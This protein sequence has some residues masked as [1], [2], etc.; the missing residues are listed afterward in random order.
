MS[1]NNERIEWL[2][3]GKGL[4][5][6][7]VV[8][9]H[10]ISEYLGVDHFGFFLVNSFSMPTFFAMSGYVVQ[11]K[12]ISFGKYAKQ[13]AKRLL[14]PYALFAM[15]IIFARIAMGVLSKANY[16]ATLTKTD[17]INTIT[18]NSKSIVSSLWFLPVLF[19]ADLV[20]YFIVR[21]LK[22]RKE[23]VI[24]CITAA[25]IILFIKNL[26]LKGTTIP[27]SIDTVIV[28]LSF[29]EL[30]YEIRQGALDVSK[31]ALPCWTFYIS[32]TIIQYFILHSKEFAFYRAESSYPL[33]SF[34]CAVSSA[35]GLIWLFQ[36]INW[37]PLIN[38]FGRHSLYIYGFHFLVQNIVQIVL[39]K[40]ILHS[41]AIMIE[42]IGIALLAAV[43]TVILTEIATTIYLWT[44]TQILS[45][46][47]KNSPVE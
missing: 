19:L 21:Y 8:I 16:L 40:R 4:M 24:V 35:I 7:S 12:D 31:W 30:G 18:F 15:L 10:S 47:L 38:R 2:D 6:F 45:R 25:V 5:I 43:I 13:K 23:R 9:A 22:N 37:L 42:T 33:L 14:P 1:K 41:K 36:K 39:C 29:L 28:A 46:Q 3:L 11:R 20:F 17:F 26:L 44:K 32:V 34:L 27:F